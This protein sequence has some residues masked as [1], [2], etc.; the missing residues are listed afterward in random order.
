MHFAC[1]SHLLSLANSMQSNDFQ[2]LEA[3]IENS[4]CI[5][6]CLILIRF[7]AGSPP[8]AFAPAAP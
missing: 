1:I 5:A 4:V 6:S 3:A 7:R 8:A 2:K